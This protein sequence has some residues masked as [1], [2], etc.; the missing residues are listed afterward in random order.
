MGNECPP[1]E[2]WLQL[3]VDT[4]TAGQRADLELHLE[5]CAAC[6]ELLGHLAGAG[7]QL[8][9]V[10]FRSP[11]ALGPETIAMLNRVAAMLCPDGHV[12]K[13]EPPIPPRVDGLIN[14]EWVGRGGMGVVLRAHEVGLDRPVA[15]KVL[16]PGGHLAPSARGRA[17]REAL[18]L[19]SL[20]HPNVV[21]VYRSGEVDVMPFLIMEWVDGG[22]LQERISRG[23]LN[24]REAAETVRDL[25]LAVSEAHALGIIH[26][27]LTP[28]NVLL[29]RS[30]LTASKYLHKLADFGL[31]RRNNEGRLTATGDALGVRPDDA[32][33][34]QLPVFSSADFFR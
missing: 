8:A 20:S 28:A 13:V 17:V 3:L 1:P 14:W 7:G 12:I 5:G 33:G 27:D 11:L 23:F 4:V 2:F 19:A 26:R 10:A 30:G 6:I 18:L 32:P 9:N 15:V 25:A 29:A 22:T 21:H 34:G 24:P 16:S 31:A